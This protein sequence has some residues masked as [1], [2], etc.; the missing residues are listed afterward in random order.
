[1]REVAII[2]A[3]EL[4]GALAHALARKNV[5]R[6]IRLID[7]KG[8]IAEGKALDIAQAAPVEGFAASLS[9]CTDIMTAAGAA[10]IVVADRAGGAEWQGED[11]L[12]LLG[13]LTRLAP[14]SVIVCAG[15]MQREIVERGVRELHIPRAGILGSAPEALAAGA[16]ALVALELDA[17]PSDL[18]LSVLGVPPGHI[19]ISWE[20]ATLCGIALAHMCDE[21]ARRRLRAR[22][23]ALWPPGPFSLGAAAAKVIETLCGRS[24]RLAC[25]FVAPDDSAGIRTRAAALP[26]RLGPG[27]V[28][29][30][31]LP[32]LT[33]AERVA[34]D[35]AMML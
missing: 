21:P 17:S 13:R 35:N 5:V 27:G 26:V 7:E 9:G 18:A 6:T 29:E 8:R 34:L 2:G 3:G 11:G 1:M 24:R 10:V 23:A 32:S 25:C 14:A 12:A 30:T 33:G 28:V 22:I 31:V 15:A 20:D 19:V 4:G 16:R